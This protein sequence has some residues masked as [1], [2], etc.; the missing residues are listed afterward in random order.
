MHKIK[1]L[2]ILCGG[3][4][5]VPAAAAAE[6]FEDLLEKA[7]PVEEM[8]TIISPFVQICGD[9]GKVEDLQ[10]RAIRSRMQQKVRGRLF[11]YS[12]PAV[13]VGEYNGTLLNYP[14]RIIGNLTMAGPVELKWGLYGGKNAWHITTAVPKKV[15]KKGKALLIDG[16]ELRDHIEK[17]GRTLVFS[18]SPSETEK[19]ERTEKVNLRV[20]FVFEYDGRTW[21]DKMAGNG[22]VVD[23]KGYRLY[24]QCTG[25]VVAS[26]PPSREKGPT[27]ADSPSCRAVLAATEDAV[28]AKEDAIPEVLGSSVIRQVMQRANPAVKECFQTYQISGLANVRVVLQNDGTVQKAEVSGQF[29]DTPTGKCI[30]DGVQNLVFPRFKRDTMS[31]SYPYHLR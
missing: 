21:P 13:E 30:I 31:F 4:L 19:W 24:N 8:E 29:A 14:A 5:L 1:M 2:F 20:Q 6:K 10:C 18:V 9:S 7:R 22:I 3:F 27:A 25:E 12:A 17:K 15:R 11:S 16:I 26:V 28:D 23:L